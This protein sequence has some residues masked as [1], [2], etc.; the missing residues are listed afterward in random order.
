VVLRVLLINNYGY[1]RGG[2]DRCFI[3]TS[4]LLLRNSHHVSYLVSSN[5]RNVVDSEYAVHGF[6]IDSPVPTDIP[7]YLYSINARHKLREL[8]RREHPDVAHLH[9]YYGQITASI[10]SVL[11]EY[12]IPVVQ[13]LHE[14]KL[15]CPVSSMVRDGRL[16][17]ECAEG[18]YW[19]AAWHR[20]NRGNLARS[21]VTATE[22]YV[23]TTLGARTG[24][25]HFIAVSDFLRGKMIEHGIPENKIT[26]VH[27]FVRDDVLADNMDEGKYFLY[28]GR[29]E[30]IKGLGTL[31]KA[32]AAMSDVDLYIV[33]S[34]GARQELEDDVA[35][36]GLANVRFLGFKSGQE[37]RG[38][39]AGAIAIVAPSECNETFGLVLVESFAQCRPVIASR[40]GGMTEVV[41]D[42]EDG[43]LFDAGNVEQLVAALAWMAANR[44]QA[45]EMGRAGQAKVRR[46]F[47]A[48]KHYQEIIR[49][50]QKVTGI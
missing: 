37:L 44:K 2:S 4:E 28:F 18:S 11:K 3:D 31:I 40:M 50:Y 38:L 49:V 34:G 17:E 1:V 27:N 35:R 29:I 10:L 19:R 16:C 32:M 46:L 8:I 25:D 47:S 42:G 45:V 21:L 14:Y 15:L 39:I 30:K 26:T 20:C 22:S 5:D 43:L 23:S 41:S 6:N 36:M 12:G 33:G 9:I 48:G 7:K 13:T 24:I